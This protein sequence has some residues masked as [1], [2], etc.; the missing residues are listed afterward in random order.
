MFQRFH[1]NWQTTSHSSLALRQAFTACHKCHEHFKI[2]SHLKAC[3][4]YLKICFAE[5]QLYLTPEVEAAGCLLSAAN[6]VKV[7]NAAARAAAK[8]EKDQRAAAKAARLAA[9]QDA[10]A[11]Q[12]A[13]AAAAAAAVTAAQADMTACFDK[14]RWMENK[15]KKCCDDHPESKISY[16]KKYR[17]K[18]S[19]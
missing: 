13:A 9:N 16:C 8:A 3:Y 14:A 17:E 18:S 2:E 11:A 7:E 15:I 10:K 4:E 19:L 12:K 1:Y 6:Q 5:N